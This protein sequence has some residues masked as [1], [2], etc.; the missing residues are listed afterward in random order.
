MNRAPGRVDAPGRSWLRGLAIATLLALAIGCRHQAVESVATEEDVPVSVKPAAVVDRFETTVSA[1][2]VVAAESGADWTIT[3]PESARIAELP[4]NEGERVKVGDL[5]VRFDIPTMAADV[6][7]READ[8]AEATAKLDTAKAALA[9]VTGLVDRGIAAKKEQEAAALDVAQAEAALKQSHAALTAANQLEERATVK[10]RFAGIIA[11]RSHGV[12]DLVEAGGAVV[13]VI[14]PSRLEV[15]ASVTVG[16]LRRVS[17][18]HAARIESSAGAA[19]EPGTVISAPAAVDPASATA[20]VRIKFNAPTKLAVGLPVNV[21]IVADTLT[22]VLV[23]PTVAILHDG[24]EVFVMVAGQDDDKAHKTP[25]TLGIASGN[26]TQITSGLN[27]GDLV[28]VRGQEGL[29]DEA[30]IT[31][32]K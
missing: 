4:K 10:A 32:V 15:V 13:R 5:L 31:V 8:V 18:G 7:A 17:L 29:P 14:D 16:D 25:V 11:K 27:A 24:A 20:D 21:T 30:G 28:I 9:R 22:K 2:G 12:G 3:A 1:T 23:I 6:A 19:P 26:Q